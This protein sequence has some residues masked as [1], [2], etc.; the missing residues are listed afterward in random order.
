MK[1][2]RRRARVDPATLRPGPIRHKTLSP[3]L[4][5]RITRL[6]SI[7]SEAYDNAPLEKWL[8]DFQ[9]DANPENEVIIWER[10]EKAFS[11][12]INN[13][14]TLEKKK[15]VLMHLLSLAAEATP[16]VISEPVLSKEDMAR[17]NK[18][19]SSPNAQ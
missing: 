8:E 16:I 11:A 12:T 17:L 15:E 10:I 9:R 18:A 4:V 2:S 5:K 7:L 6:Q 3:D 1:E 13:T 19:W 14:D